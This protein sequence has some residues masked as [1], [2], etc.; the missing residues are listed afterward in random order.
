MTMRAGRVRHVPGDVVMDNGPAIRIADRTIGRD[1]RPYVIAEMSANHG[2][3][4]DRARR[5]IELA[6]ACGADAVKLQAYKADSLTLDCDGPGFVIEADTPWKGR[7]LHALYQDSATPYEW[8]PELFADA[9][10]CGIAA[11]VSPFDVEAVALLA[12]LD[13][14][15]YKIASFEAVDL[16]MIRACAA[17][18]KPMIISVGLC[19]EEEIEDALAAARGAGARE[20]ALLKCTSAYP[21]RPEEANLVTIPAMI[22]RFQVPVGLS[23]HSLGAAVAISAVALGATLIEKHFI[24]AR[25]PATADSSFSA[26]PEELEAL[27]K[28]VETAFEARGRPWYGPVERE[29]SS[30]TFRRSLYAVDDIPAGEPLTR[31]NVRS[32]RP[33]LGLAPRYLPQI[34]GRAVRA[35]VARGTPLDWEMVAGPED[36]S[37]GKRGDAL[38]LRDS[39]RD[40]D[41]ARLV[42]AWRNDELTRSASFN[43]DL[44]RWPDFWKGYLARQADTRLPKPQVLEDD[45]WP[46]AFVSF[47]RPKQ[48]HHS[49]GGNI[50]VSIFVA[51]EE[52]GRGYGL[53]ALTMVERFL[54][55]LGYRRIVALVKPDNAP[56]IRLFRRAG[57][58]RCELSQVDLPG[59][60]D[61]PEVITYLREI[62][63]PLP[64]ALRSDTASGVSLEPFLAEHVDDR[65][66]GWLNDDEVM[67][68]TETRFLR[69]TK[70]TALAYIETTLKNP[71]AR[72]WRIVAPEGMHVGT[73]R[74][75]RIEPLHRRA[76][77]AFIVGER[78]YRRTEAAA[79][80]IDLV[81]G[82]AFRDL[83]LSKLEAVIY[84][85]NDL[86]LDAFAA[87]GFHEEGILKRHFFGT[88]RFVDSILM[89]RF[90]P[91]AATPRRS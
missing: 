22:E 39:R 53:A 73:I 7:R 19:S 64:P 75:A 61:R 16:E 66:V 9:R 47:D 49:E 10:E 42:M 70:N 82:F 43:T 85:D 3:D 48:A 72:L 5:I 77:L 50:E 29:R 90:G 2:G 20:I 55:N 57:Y 58:V 44:L 32:I 45:G 76:Q 26:V 78:A 27:V 88:A 37:P 14:P 60:A 46:V 25:E 12:S 91:Q 56:S 31:D 1:H 13:A 18:G 34:L 87:A 35:E 17:T 67:R 83:G 11:F 81:A 28:G 63:P 62:V 89:A 54:A 24:D 41:E 38:A 23:D 69:H 79:Q 74:L 51:P 59:R 86:G 68:F 36:R 15:A 33:G 52:R 71:T 65:Y 30:L 8:L 40:D 6:A 4:I 80:A 84:A 21:A